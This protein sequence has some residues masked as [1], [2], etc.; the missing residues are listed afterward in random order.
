M[1]QSYKNS[2]RKQE[3]WDQQNPSANT[4]QGHYRKGRCPL[5]STDAKFSIN[6]S[7]TESNEPSDPYEGQ[8]AP[9]PA[10]NSGPT[11]TATGV[12]HPP[13]RQ[14]PGRTGQELPSQQAENR[15]SQQAEG[16]PK[17]P[18]TDENQQHPQI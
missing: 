3:K 17:N 9:A 16:N 5:M 8:R 10:D 12:T 18:M 11:V 13:P 7:H 4:R 15:R 6:Y 1:V 14:L 2:S